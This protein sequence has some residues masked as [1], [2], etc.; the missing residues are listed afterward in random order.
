[1]AEAVADAQRLLQ[2]LLDLQQL[3]I[4]LEKRCVRTTQDE[5]TR[6]KQQL[7][8]TEQLMLYDQIV[9]PR[10]LIE[11]EAEL[12]HARGRLGRLESEHRHTQLAEGVILQKLSVMAC[13]LRGISLS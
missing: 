8:H 9:L 11:A 4:D 5:V 10:K 13:R 6:L 2:Q 3:R 12:K 7:E 1:M